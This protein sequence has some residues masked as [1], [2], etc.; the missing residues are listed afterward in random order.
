MTGHY[1]P[2][3]ALLP[4]V[5]QDDHRSFEQLDSYLGLVDNL[6]RAYVQRLENLQIWLSPNAITH[7]WPADSRVDGGADPVIDSYARLYD[8]LASWT[9]FA[10]PQ[11]WTV[12]VDGVT[13]PDLARRRRYLARAARIWR[14]R[15]T[16]RGFVDWIS[17][18]FGIEP[19]MHPFFLE[20]FKFGRPECDDATEPGPEPW[21]RATLL[22]R[23]TDR[24]D[25]PEMRR[26]V[27]TFVETYAPAHVH[28]RVCWVAEDFEL[29]ETED[30]VL[31]LPGPRPVG[32]DAAAVGEWEEAV[33]AF[34]EHIKCLLCSLV[35]ETSHQS[36]MAIA[37]CVDAGEG[38]DRLG[39]GRLPGGGRIPDSPADP[40]P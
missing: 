31:P 23:S 4:S 20:H 27:T 3:A 14:R 28:V 2:L 30:G 38:K 35:G 16:P 37:D 13:R 19:A 25:R 6:Q 9:G 5:Y 15:G 33:A 29:Y 10:F 32:A 26:L 12:E 18:A 1:T 7:S 36:A 21:L 22:M 11:W 39:H 17:F 40:T 24:F 34:Q 8:E